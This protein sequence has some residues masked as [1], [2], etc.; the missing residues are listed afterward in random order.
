MN[1]TI[2]LHG[3]ERITVESRV[4]DN[5]VNMRLMVIGPDGLE[6]EINVF[7]DKALTVEDVGTKD[8]RKEAA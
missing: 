2:N 1:T 8:H 5:F 3:A 4:F 7:A 6:A